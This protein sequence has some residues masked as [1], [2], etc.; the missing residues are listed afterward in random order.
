MVDTWTVSAI[1]RNL[2][3]KHNFY[4]STDVPFTGSG[5]GTAAGVLG[6]GFASIGRGREALFQVTFK[7]GK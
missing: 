5:T 7:L 1:G 3:D 6:D 4:A 2:T